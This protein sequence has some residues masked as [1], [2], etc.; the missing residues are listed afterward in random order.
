MLKKALFTVASVEAKKPTVGVDGIWSG[1]DW[2]DNASGIK[3][4][5]GMLEGIS[6][7]MIARIEGASPHSATDMQDIYLDQANVQMVKS[8]LSEDQ[9][10]YLFPMAN[11]IY[12]YDSFLMAVGKFPKFCG[13]GDEKLCKRELSTIFAHMTHEVGA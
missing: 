3:D 11:E 2:V 8:V 13:D 7:E 6:D 10:D 12:D 9:W 5:N 4:I 1:H